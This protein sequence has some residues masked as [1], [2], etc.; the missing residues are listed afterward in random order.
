[1]RNE[2]KRGIVRIN[3]GAGTGKTT[4]V[5]FRVI[6]LMFNGVKPEEILLISFTNVAAKEMKDRIRIYA[7]D[8]GL[9]ADIDK[10]RVE[11]FHS[12]GN[13]IL[14]DKWPELGFTKEPQVID[15]ISRASIISEILEKYDIPGL[16]YRNFTMRN[17]NALGALPQTEDAFKAIKSERLGRGDEERLA[18]KLGIG[19]STAEA[20]LK[21]FDDYD[22]ML[23][24]RGFIE[25]VDMESMIFEVF[26]KDPFY[27]DQFGIRHVI[28]DEF[29]DTS[30][31]EIELVK[32]LRDTPS[33]ES[34]MVVGDDSQAIYGFNDT[35]PDFIINFDDAIGEKADT[36]S[37]VENFRSTRNIIDFANDIND[38]NTNKVAKKLISTLPAGKPVIVNGFVDEDEQYDY[39]IDKIKEKLENGVKPEDIAILA[40]KKTALSRYGDRLEKAGIEAR[41]CYPE[42]ILDN[43]R[44][45]AAIGLFKAVKDNN[46]NQDLLAYLNCKEKGKLME[47]DIEEVQEMSDDFMAEIEGLEVLSDKERKEEIEKWLHDIDSN[48]DEV[49]NHFLEE[50]FKRNTYEEMAQYASDF[51]KF[52]EGETF[53][54]TKIYPGIQLMTAHSSKGLE[55]PIVFDDINDYEVKGMSREEAEEARRLLFVSATRAKEELYVLGTYVAYGPEKDHTYNRFLRESYEIVGNEFA[56]SS[57]EMQIKLRKEEKKKLKAE[58]K[59]EKS[60]D[61]EGMLKISE[62][63]ED[64]PSK[65]AV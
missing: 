31:K 53:K 64:K 55:Y 10:L 28:V 44:V 5:T 52:G 4:V 33:F 47:M 65:K 59:K 6:T 27:L 37:L 34:L 11:T 40:R 14:R 8:M 56:A 60:L 2:E 51:E 54:R 23:R 21:A 32:L 26:H 35:T 29:Q 45:K 38:R 63:E 62:I 25:F 3:A 61:L 57:I 13:S 15:N 22:D 43:C 46:D 48:E 17:P 50:L 49:Y 24:E 9:E 39:V 18:C 1:M 19:L 7:A 30:R 36:I 42:K 58:E 41:F 20:L 16:D 12:F